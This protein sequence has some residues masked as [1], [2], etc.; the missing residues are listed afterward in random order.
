MADSEIDMGVSKQIIFR[1]ELQYGDVKWVIRRTIYDFYKLHLT[2]TAKRFENLP[3]FPSQVSLSLAGAHTS[4]L[5][6]LG[7]D[8]HTGI[9]GPVIDTASLA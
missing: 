1:V 7:T 4:Y 8:H 9:F 2:L 6:S 5:R 3:K